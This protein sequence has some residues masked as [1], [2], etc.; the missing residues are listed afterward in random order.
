MSII[1]CLTWVRRGVAKSSP[2]KVKLEKEDLRRI[3]EETREELE[4]DEPSDTSEEEEEKEETKGASGGKMQKKVEKIDKKKRKHEDNGTTE[5]DDIVDKYGL[6]DYDDDNNE[7]ERNPLKGLGNLVYYT[8]NDDD[9]YITLKDEKDSDDEEYEIKNT[10]NMVVVG[11]ATEECCSLDVYI[12]NEEYGNLYIH[13]DVILSTF[14]LCVEWLNYDVCD[15]DTGNFVAV[16]TM[17]P[18]IEIWDLDVV[19]SLEPVAMLGNKPTKNKKK[20]KMKGISGHTDS[21]LD[22]SWNSSVRNVLASASADSTLGLWDLDEGK[23]VTSITQHKDKVQSVK[24]HPVESQS[25]LSG[26]FDNT[27]KVFDCRSP[28]DT[29]KSWTLEGEIERVIWDT[30]SPLNFFAS[31]DTG[32]VYYLDSRTDKPLYTL[33]AHNKAVTGLALSSSVRGLLSTVSADQ[34]LKVWDVVDNKPSLILEK[35]LKLNE[36]HCLGACPEAPFV[37]AVG[38][39]KELRVWDIRSSA[40]VRKHFYDRAPSGVTME[41]LDDEGET[42]AAFETLD[43]DKDSDAEEMEE[44]IAG[45]SGAPQTTE[46]TAS[47]SSKK[48]KKKKKKPKHKPS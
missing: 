38:G 16:G 45:F 32:R 44:L 47:G 23:M 34:T 28:N 36:L 29:F 40:P 8:S 22:L 11:K 2:E 3:I 15:Q 30:Y 17:D 19:D 39:E 43:L 21:V 35:N 10:D 9:P 42:T 46:M 27:V 4:E 20:K 14:P 24:W 41:D 5:G 25:L 26:S 31:T 1:P 33:S 6:D 48:K 37:F 13:H 12:Y 7:D 18:V